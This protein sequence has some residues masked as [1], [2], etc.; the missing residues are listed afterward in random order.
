MSFLS[1]P[2]RFA[3]FACIV[4]CLGSYEQA[5]AGTWSVV[6]KG[7]GSAVGTWSGQS[8]LGT[9]E[10]WTPPAI[11]AGTYNASAELPGDGALPWISYAYFGSCTSKLNLTLTTTVTYVPAEGATIETDP[12]PATIPITEASYA[13]ASSNGVG[14]AASASAS[15]G[16][17]DITKSTQGNTLNIYYAGSS[18]QGSHTK[19]YTVN[20]SNNTASVTLPTRTL[21]SSASASGSGQ[22]DGEGSQGAGY[23]VT[24]GDVSYTVTVELP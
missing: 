6:I 20:R 22:V 1:S 17:G 23:S 4:L 9:N 15:N 14:G 2:H 10:T 13:T 7:S 24:R 16:L 18:S 21:T 12:P 8:G 19:T 3:F 11:G 5:H